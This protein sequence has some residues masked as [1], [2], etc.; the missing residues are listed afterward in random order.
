MKHLKS[1]EQNNNEPHIGD[2]IIYLG[3][4]G[5]YDIIQITGEK[6]NQYNT[7]YLYF[8]EEDTIKKYLTQF[9]SYIYKSNLSKVL[10][11]SDNLE[12]CMKQFQMIID[13]KKYNL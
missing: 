9:T 8:I 10:F 7:I 3:F 2:Y 5:D 1:F 6:D 4:G 13:A 11:I 12:D